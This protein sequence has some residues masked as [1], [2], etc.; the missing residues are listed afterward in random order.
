MRD[1]IEWGLDG[2]WIEYGC[3]MDIVQMLDRRRIDAGKM[4]DRCRGRWGMRSR[5]FVLICASQ[6]LWEAAL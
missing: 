4:L 6:A 1:L 5:S 3:P 2:V